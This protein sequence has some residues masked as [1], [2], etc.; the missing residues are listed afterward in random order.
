ML[1]APQVV[2]TEAQATAVVR[3]TVP[4]SEIRNV[5]GP[6]IG[7]VLAAVTAQGIGPAGPVCARHFR[8]DPAVFEFEV[9]VPVRAPV[10]PTG[11]VQPGDL[12]A[13]T[14]ASA[15]YTGPYEGLGDAW[16][17]F[18]RWIAAQG[19]TPA[20]GLW[21]CYL[22]GPESGEDPSKWRTQLNRPIL[23]VKA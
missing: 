11:R 16:G 13:A 12:P 3:L 8:M 15:T 14:V 4:R 9:G 6:A 22:A 10:R 7:E 5:M 23:T 1:D 2:K 17:E 19:H 21:E 18:G 20:P